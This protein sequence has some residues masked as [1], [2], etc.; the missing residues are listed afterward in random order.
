M[1]TTKRRSDNLFWRREDLLDL[2]VEIFNFIT[3]TTKIEVRTEQVMEYLKE[4]DP[5]TNNGQDIEG[6]KN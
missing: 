6:D 3:S 2:E 1:L 4:I 5:H